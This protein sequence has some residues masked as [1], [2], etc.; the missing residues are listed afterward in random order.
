MSTSANRVQTRAKNANTHPGN[1]LKSTSV[2]RTPQ[3][4]AAD[5]IAADAAKKKEEGKRNGSILRLARLEGLAP[6]A[7]AESHNPLPT[8]R[9]SKKANGSR[10]TVNQKKAKR[11][12]VAS[13]VLTSQVVSTPKAS[14]TAT[15]GTRSAAGTSDPFLQV[16]DDAAA[17]PPKGSGKRKS[18]GSSSSSTA[19]KARSTPVAPLKASPLSIPGLPP[20]DEATLFAILKALPQARATTAAAHGTTLNAGNDGPALPQAGTINESA[21]FVD[22]DEDSEASFED[23]QD[24]NMDDEDISDG[25]M[26]IIVPRIRLASESGLTTGP[27]NDIEIVGHKKISETVQPPRLQHVLEL[28]KQFYYFWSIKHDPFADVLTRSAPLADAIRKAAKQLRYNNVYDRVCGDN[29]YLK[30]LIYVPHQ[31]WTVARGMLKA[32][33]VKGVVAA[34]H[35]NIADPKTCCEQ[36]EELLT[37]DEAGYLYVF[38]EMDSQAGAS[39]TFTANMDKPYLRPFLLQLLR[40]AREIAVGHKALLPALEDDLRSESPDEDLKIP[41]PLLALAA[42]AIHAALMDYEIGKFGVGSSGSEG[43]E[44]GVAFSADR[45]RAAYIDHLDTLDSI[46]NQPETCDMFDPLLAKIWRETYGAAAASRNRRA[47]SSTS[48]LAVKIR[49]IDLN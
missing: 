15:A 13:V 35:L 17:A 37:R 27:K 26:M 31:R 6:V 47:P 11:D 19:K 24:I 38:A 7:G 2:R 41:V 12:D 32:D 18:T 23:N 29:D 5:K 21:G 40:N 30:K 20:L 48:N 49:K 39:Q 36:V 22:D 34:Y 43:K 4:I 8:P 1:V 10:T 3:Q 14:V 46:K 44:K 25:A 9:A 16:D 42:T 45:F 33:A 28:A